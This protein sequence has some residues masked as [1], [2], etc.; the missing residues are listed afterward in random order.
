MI[1]KDSSWLA[2]LRIDHKYEYILKKYNWKLS[3]YG[4]AKLENLQREDGTRLLEGFGDV[5]L[6]HYLIVD[7]EY[8]KKPGAWLVR[9]RN[10]NPLDNRLV[11]LEI[12]QSPYDN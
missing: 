8:N 6:M 7:L 4:R 5:V 9:H 2:D 11:N 3:D 12:I 10:K 1:S